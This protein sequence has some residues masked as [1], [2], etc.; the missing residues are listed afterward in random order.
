MIRRVLLALGA[1]AL[2]FASF[3]VL[4]QRGVGRLLDAPRVLPGEAALGAVRE[5]AA[6]VVAP[7]RL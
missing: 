7:A 3:G 2:P 5:S 6:R 4:V 1:V